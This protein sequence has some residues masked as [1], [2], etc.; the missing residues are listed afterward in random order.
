MAMWCAA[1]LL[2]LIGAVRLATGDPYSGIGLVVS[3]VPFG[4]IAHSGGKALR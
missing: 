1:G 3:A 4:V 2:A